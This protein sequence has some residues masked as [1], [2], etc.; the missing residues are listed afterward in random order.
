MTMQALYSSNVCWVCWILDNDNQCSKCNM[1]Y[2]TM[3][4]QQLTRNRDTSFT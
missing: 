3:L 1:Y 2:F 4:K